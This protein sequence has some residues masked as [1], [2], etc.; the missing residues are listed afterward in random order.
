MIK[1]GDI[2]SLKKT[3]KWCYYERQYCNTS[4]HFII[5]YFDGRFADSYYHYDIDESFYDTNYMV[6]GFSYNDKYGVID[7]V[8]IDIRLGRIVT[9]KYDIGVELNRII[10]KIVDKTTKDILKLSLMYNIDITK[11]VNYIEYKDSKELYKIF[12]NKLNFYKALLSK[13]NEE[14]IYYV[15]DIV[16]YNVYNKREYMIAN[17]AYD[18]TTHT[19]R[20]NLYNK[21]KQNFI[22]VIEDEDLTN[23]Y[24]KLVKR[25]NKNII[26]NTVI[27]KIE[28]IMGTKFK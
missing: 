23:S 21:E 8:V 12:E 25:G 20:F 2:I 1:Q 19:Y 3:N 4:N 17:I 24:L 28:E 5:K 14:N 18:D 15:G 22:K 13:E 7:L 10:K 9:L 26:H 27:R 16:T 6:K 11:E